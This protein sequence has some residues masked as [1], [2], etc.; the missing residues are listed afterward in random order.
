LIMF[1]PVKYQPDRMYLRHV[2]INRVHLFTFFQILCLGILWV[3]KAIKTI[4]IVF[5]VMVL[6]TCFVRK[7]M[8][9][10]FTMNELK[11]LDDQNLEDKMMKQEDAGE[12]IV[13]DD[14]EV[15]DFVDE[16]PI[17]FLKQSKCR[18]INSTGNISW[19]LKRDST[20]TGRSK[21][22]ILK[23]CPVEFLRNYRRQSTGSLYWHPNDNTT[24]HRRDRK[25]DFKIDEDSII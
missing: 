13:E 8:E 10:I 20:S 3:I 17:E 22:D 4:S 9:R 1:M 6:G 11:W 19:Y 25:I 16:G 18:K 23:D 2:R 7:G 15:D 24:M 14:D 21:E 5:P 12:L